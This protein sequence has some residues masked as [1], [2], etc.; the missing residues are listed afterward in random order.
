MTTCN[1]FD[2]SSTGTNIECSVFY[3]TMKS[4]IDFNDN[5]KIIQHSGYRTHTIGYYIDHRNVENHDAITFTLEGTP[6]QIKAALK[7]DGYEDDDDTVKD[8]L[9]ILENG[10][11]EKITLLNYEDFNRVY[12]PLSVKPSKVLEKII[13]RGYSQGDYAEV[14]YCPDDLEKAWGKKPDENELQKMVDH[15][16]WD[17][18]IYASI[19]INGDEY[20]YWDQPEYDEYEWGRDKFIKYVAEKSGVS[21]ETLDAILSKEPSYD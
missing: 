6:E 1:N 21:I 8:A 19:T 13:T 14:F 2:T 15:Y 20:N 16:F 18:P 10:Y 4:Q 12:D 9:E 3:D 7:Q 5:I 17:T 11:G